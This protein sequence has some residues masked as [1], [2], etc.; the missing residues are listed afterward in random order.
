MLYTKLLSALFR[1]WYGE[2]SLVA[3]GAET[4][5]VL[6]ADGCGGIELCEL[7]VRQVMGERGGRH[8]VTPVRW[9]HG[10]GRWYKDLSDEANH[11]AHSRAI[12]EQVL[13][14]RERSPSKPVFL[15]GKSGGTW[16]AVRAL[17]GLPAD[18]VEAAV[19]LAP[20]I[21]PDYDLSRALRA[22]RREMV[23]FWSPFD[24]IVLGAGT[25]LFKTTDRVRS[26]SAGLVGFRP[27]ASLDDE[28]L[29]LYKK[30]RLVRWRSAMARTG[31]LGGHV[32]PDSPAFLRKYV[33]P[34]LTR[35]ESHEM[36]NF[37]RDQAHPTPRR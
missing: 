34:L 16:I 9:G 26:V 2:P 19:L 14:W 37:P 4:G 7:G 8:R 36:L 24:L 6:V 15:V 28:G 22:V 32:G 10:F 27:P 20:A 25:W 21:S 33:V 13:A 1:L 18:S 23:A 35:P 29:S 12:V 17:E 3:E 11:A 30:L 5:L 31:Y